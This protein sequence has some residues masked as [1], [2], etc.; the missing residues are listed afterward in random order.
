MSMPRA[1]PRSQVLCS[2]CTI[3]FERT[4]KSIERSTL[5]HGTFIC[6]KCCWNSPELKDQQRRNNLTSIAYKASRETVSEKMK[7]AGN[8][9]WGT[10]AS[11]ET[12]AKMSVSRS[13]KFG[14]NATAWKGGARSLNATVKT[15]IN[16]RHGW[17]KKIYARDGWKCTQ[18]EST[19]ILDAH[20]VIP[21]SALMKMIKCPDLS[22]DVLI[23]WLA[24]N[25]ILVKA[26]GI[27][28]CRLCHRAAH[29]NWG[30][31]YAESIK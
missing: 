14:E 25:P 3:M 28:L 13:G 20:H 23:D 26:E 6:R 2:T 16:R 22:G 21:F 8:H 27:T 11:K 10:I 19:K 24:N 30:S 1:Q 4:A 5:K 9:R 12:K 17:A 7:G 29:T 31:H 18:C 15:A